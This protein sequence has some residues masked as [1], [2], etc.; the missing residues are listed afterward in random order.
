M[1]QLYQNEAH[2]AETVTAYI[3]EGLR[4]GEGVIV[5]AT[6]AHWELSLGRLMRQPRRELVDAVLRQQLRLLDAEVTLAAFMIDGLPQWNRFQEAVCP[7]INQTQSRF[8]RV[9]IYGEM[10]DVLWQE[11]NQKA[12]TRLEQFW[13]RLA[14]QWH[15]SLLCAYRS[16]EPDAGTYLDVPATACKTHSHLMAS[17]RY[18]YQEQM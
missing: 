3:V 2:L 6:A 16:R 5:V 8:G 7:V 14:K 17:R 9:R 10:V 4:S 13:S 15:F 11:G 18:D 12:V 1:A